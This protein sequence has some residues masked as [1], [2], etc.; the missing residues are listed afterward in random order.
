V[1]PPNPNVPE[2][3][4]M[5]PRHRLPIDGSA[6]AVIT[7][8]HYRWRWWADVDVRRVGFPRDPGVAEVRGPFSN[9]DV[10]AWSE[11]AVRAKADRLASKLLHQ[12]VDK[13]YTYTR[14]LPGGDVA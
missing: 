10:S 6:E 8:G 1:I 5:N 11:E 9:H 3:R 2:R 13:P 12:P 4:S 14:R 7:V